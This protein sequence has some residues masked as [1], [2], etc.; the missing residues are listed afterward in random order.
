M[1]DNKHIL[2]EAF[3]KKARPSRK[4][5]LNLPQYEPV[6]AKSKGGNI[7]GTYQVTD[8]DEVKRRLSGTFGVMFG[9][10]SVRSMASRA[11][12]Q[13]PI[14]VSD[15]VSPETVVMLK[16]L[17]EEQYAEYI[18]LMINN[19]V[20]D[21]SDYSAGEVDGN[22]AIQALD[23]ISGT[24]FGKSK[25]ADKI[26]KGKNNP[27]DIFGNIPLYTLLREQNQIAIKTPDE[28]VNALLEN[29]IITKPE[30]VTAVANFINENASDIVSLLE[31]PTAEDYKGEPTYDKRKK[32]LLRQYLMDIENGEKEIDKLTDSEMLLDIKRGVSYDKAGNELYSRLTT[33]DIVIDADKMDKAINRS[34]GAILTDPENVEIRDRFEKATFLLQSRRISGY[35]YFNYVTLRLGLPVSKEAKSA[36]LKNFRIK[37]VVSYEGVDTENVDT[38][39]LNVLSTKQVD[40]IAKNE[41]IVKSIVSD[42]SKV[43]GKELIMPALVGGSVGAG[44]VA[45]GATIAGVAAL[46]PIGLGLLGGAI[47]GSGAYALARL[48]KAKVAKK[49]NKK[50]QKRLGL[51]KNIEGWERVES[52]IQSLERAQSDI[53]NDS[54]KIKSVYTPISKPYEKDIDISKNKE[55]FVNLA[56]ELNKTRTLVGSVL[57]ESCEPR[58]ISI[59][60]P[61]HIEEYYERSCKE[62]LELCEELDQDEDF[63]QDMLVEAK[64]GSLSML[65]D[66]PSPVTVKYIEKKPGKDA[67]LM[68]SSLSTRVRY[69]Y[70]STEIERKENKDRRYDQPL[71]MTVKFKER[72]S[73]GKFA[74]NELTAV[75]GILGKVIRIPSEEMEYVL[76][77][78]AEGKTL[79]GF[80]KSDLVNNISD[81]LS[82]NK[83][84]KDL[85]GLPKSGDIWHNL[86]KVSTLA[87][88]N[89]LSGKRNGNIANA[90]IV[91]SQKE[92]DNVRNDTD[93]NYITDNKKTVAL[94]KRYSALTIMVANDVGQRLSIF[95]DQ[96]NI[97]WNVIPYSAIAGKDGGDQLTA[98][99]AKLSRL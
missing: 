60:T 49:E 99:L 31:Y 52:L 14:L 39:S 48:Y 93:V 97:S 41:R 50:E 90:H 95:D 58:K 8:A 7:T 87:A 17:M 9:N 44:A 42:I 15:N 28:K 10:N 16:K 55:N 5:A 56:S 61:D 34:V 91:F 1:K 79:E 96:D 37:D 11:I 4:E 76:K 27:D 88:A 85:K 6:E 21:L 33:A 26:G 20:I 89:K 66:G 25:I 40:A 2:N 12:K 78:N 77:E 24:E 81:M 86:E 45:S 43:S 68:P 30:D 84:S 67:L 47:I 72:F 59:A 94:M 54:N 74:D 62:L 80:F 32:R 38:D 51:S 46:G 57:R 75:I 71:V 19:Q 35:E 3:F 65:S 53:R 29:A 70:G 83:V 23:T 36:L 18:S 13:F 73:D 92:I 64:L 69:A 22:I 98:A 63:C 82:M